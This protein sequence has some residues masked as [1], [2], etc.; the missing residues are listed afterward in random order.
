MGKPLNW[1]TIDLSTGID[2][3]NEIT[4]WFDLEWNIAE[5]KL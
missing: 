2:A 4:H 3:V 5:Q 1:K